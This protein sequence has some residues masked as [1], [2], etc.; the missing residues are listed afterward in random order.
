MNESRLTPAEVTQWV[1]DFRNHTRELT[2]KASTLPPVDF[3]S[4]DTMRLIGYQSTPEI[5][6]G[7]GEYEQQFRD[8][9]EGHH[10]KMMPFYDDVYWL[11]INAYAFGVIAGIRKERQRR[12]RSFAE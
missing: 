9:L 12:R 2:R 3:E 8:I 1:E 4:N 7:G 11:A 10:A 5:M 6:P